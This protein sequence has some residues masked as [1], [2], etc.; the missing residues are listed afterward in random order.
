MK[1]ACCIWALSGDETDIL[2]QVRDLG[3][4]WIDIQPAQLASIESRLLAQELGLS[5]SC[6]GAS[7]GMPAGSALDAS[8]EGARRSAS[9]HVKRALDKAA[10]LRADT[11][12]VVPGQRRDPAALERFAQSLLPLADRAAAAGIKLAIEHFPGKA[13]PT[14]AETLEFLRALEH[15]NLY[16]LY[17]SGHILLSCED[18][19]AV[20][21]NAGERLGYVHF[22]DNDGV[23][24]L[25]WALLDGV[26]D[27]E[28]LAATLHALSDIGYRGA[29]S[30]E[31]SPALPQVAPALSHSADI[32]ARARHQARR[33]G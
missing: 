12:Y 18:P 31:L 1:I 13:L 25:H 2:R 16:L 20:I 19:A 26:M 22:D 15:G 33:S 29:L 28:A 5:V 24:D 30:L 7:F 27:E 17:D 11:V 14:A 8:D 3:F 32:L 10:Q 4:D 23:Q 21:H 6:V 9:E